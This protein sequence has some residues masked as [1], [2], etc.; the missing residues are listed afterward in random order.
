S[1]IGNRQSPMFPLDPL[2]IL[3]VTGYSVGALLP[4]WM[5]VQLV[6]HRSKLSTLERLLAA[7]A[8]TMG[9][10]HTSN[11]AI[12]LHGLFA[13]G[14]DTWTT[15]LR[16]ADTIAV[17]SITFAY[18]F[19]LHVHLHLW[20]NAHGR[21]LNRSEQV[22]VYMSYL[23]TIFLLVAVPR[24][25]IGDYAPM[26]TKLSFFVIPFA[27]W[28]AYV[29]GLIAVTEL[30]IARKSVNR[31]E[32]LIMRTLAA[33]FIGVGVV[34]FVAIGVELGAGTVVGSY[35]RTIANLGSLLPSA[36][37]AYYIYRYRYLEIIIEKSLVVVTFA[38]VVLTVYV[39]G[40]RT[41]GDW[42][43]QRYGVRPG[44]VEALLILTLALLAAPLR[45]WLAQRFHKLFEREAALYKEILSRIGAYAGQYKDL[46]DLLHFVEERTTHAL[47]L[48]KLKIFTDVSDPWVKEILELSQANGWEPVEDEPLLLDQGFKIAYPMRREE[49]VEGLL[50]VDASAAMLTTD[51]RSVMELL[52]G[53]VAIAID[54]SRLLEENIRL[55]RELAERER[56]AALGRMAATVAHEIKNPLSAIKSIAQ[57]MR[58]DEQLK[59][60]YER[61]LRLIIGET[62]R[63]SQSVTQ[64]LSFARKESAAEQPLAIDE[65]LHSVVDLF[66]A[67]AKEQAISLECEITCDAKLVGKCVSALRDAVSNLLLNALQATPAGGRVKLVANAANGE[68]SIS[69]EDSGAGVPVEL[70]E[71]IWEPFFTTRQ[72]GTGLGLAIVRKRV[73][74]VGGSASLG[75]TRNGRGA[76]FHL[77]LPIQTS[78]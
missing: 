52:A 20:A 59:T 40:I 50:A 48:R 36:L 42:M 75:T 31:S 53:Q 30:L 65:L 49:N 32:K 63:L 23:P 61:D 37:L 15:L 51:V 72:R 74:E 38:T 47:G 57:V 34:I 24:L 5:A 9:G 62:D 64:L 6:L 25:W 69:V 12:T 3:Q 13:L 66:H 71:R 39:F 76:V 4:L 45:G 35:L 60:E 67:N 16:V 78:V 33:S 54:D 44:L 2:E 70:R 1:A 77:R 19:L 73:Q 56:L 22:R 55:E 8:L 68:L 46:S 21:N 7:L 17:V 14:P 41:I 27:F 43:T 18:S 26:F 11:L 10:W 28:I 58:E 29:L